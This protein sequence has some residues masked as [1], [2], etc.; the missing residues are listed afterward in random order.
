M[1]L[2]KSQYGTRPLALRGAALALIL[3]VGAS[4]T[5]RTD[6]AA[7]VVGERLGTTE[8]MVLVESADPGDAG[9]AGFEIAV[10]AGQA[11]AATGRTVAGTQTRLDFPAAESPTTEQANTT[12]TAES[13]TSAG[14]AKETA[15]ADQDVAGSDPAT[16][17]QAS[18]TDVSA[19]DAA[20]AD[21]PAQAPVA[22]SAD[23]GSDAATTSPAETTASSSPSTAA[24]PESSAATEQSQSAQS[25]NE[26]SQSAQTGN[27]QT[28]TAQADEIQNTQS[29]TPATDALVVR[30][31]GRTEGPSDRAAPED[32]PMSEAASLACSTVEL[33]LG[34]L[35]RGD[36]G[37]FGAEMGIAAGFTSSAPEPQISSAASSL[38]AAA[39][40]ADPVPIVSDFLTACVALGYQL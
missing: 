31:A 2:R 14:S 7:P 30:G 34:D 32:V 17:T 4:C 19:D 27:G 23:A 10:P 24:D 12:A 21:Q 9:L 13:A 18:A 29:Q 8:Q 39:L 15:P 38:N 26:Q 37:Q 5:V 25:Q 16:D 3:A 35:D 11:A 33:A 36:S 40:A 22:D 6:E 1:E 28:Q 20:A